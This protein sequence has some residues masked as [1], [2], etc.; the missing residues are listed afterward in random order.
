MQCH[1]CHGD[2]NW[3]VCALSHF[4]LSQIVL[5]ADVWG[6]LWCLCVCY[7]TSSS[8][9]AEKNR[10]N[11]WGLL[12]ALWPEIGCTNT[13]SSDKGPFS[14]EPQIADLANYYDEKITNFLLLSSPSASFQLQRR[15]VQAWRV[16][17]DE[18]YLWQSCNWCITVFWL[19]ASW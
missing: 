17:D 6:F 13:Y 8:V 4:T 12:S 10:G 3:A 2:R 14:I 16:A 9:C 5:S 15:I 1:S 11:T 7:H 18:D 19:S